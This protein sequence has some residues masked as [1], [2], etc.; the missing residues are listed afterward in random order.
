MAGR[1]KRR[2]RRFKKF[3]HCLNVLNKVLKLGTER[4]ECVFENSIEV[5][6]AVSNE[7]QLFLDCSSHRR[8]YQVAINL[9]HI[10]KLHQP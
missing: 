9:Q 10:T 2:E 4:A 8:L 7:V 1:R 3:V 6:I 5:C